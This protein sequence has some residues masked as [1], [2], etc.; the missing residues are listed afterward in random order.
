MRKM[1]GNFERAKVSYIFRSRSDEKKFRQHSRYIRH[2][3]SIWRFGRH[4]GEKE[5]L[6]SSD[7]KLACN[8]WQRVVVT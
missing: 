3:K 8:T 1:I 6:L 4:R 7:A 2:H 5:W